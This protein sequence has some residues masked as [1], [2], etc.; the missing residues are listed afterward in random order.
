MCVCVRVRAVLGF[1]GWGLGI[2]GFGNE[3]FL[4]YPFSDWFQSNCKRQQLVGSLDPSSLGYLTFVTREP[5]KN[6]QFERP[7]IGFFKKLTINR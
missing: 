5:L 4:R 1:G 6:W 2:G 3:S 7:S